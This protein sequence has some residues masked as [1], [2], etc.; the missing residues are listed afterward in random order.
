M[1]CSILKNIDLI[2]LSKGTLYSNF[3]LLDIS[4]H[5]TKRSN[6]TYIDGEG[7]QL[8]KDDLIT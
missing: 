3:T 2:N 8:I 4:T 7:L 5:I 6:I 1:L